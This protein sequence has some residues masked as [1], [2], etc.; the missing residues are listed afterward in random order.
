M[1]V[2]GAISGVP[3]VREWKHSSL[4]NATTLI[5]DRTCLRGRSR[6]LS[7][8]DGV[9]GLTEIFM[10]KEKRTSSVIRSRT[11][12][13]ACATTFDEESENVSCV[14]DPFLETHVQGTFDE[15]SKNVSCVRNPFLETHVCKLRF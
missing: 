3:S 8:R 15:K 11:S 2:Q 9:G 13:I 7:P 5:Y 6:L 1:A 10:N 4:C 12:S 14:R